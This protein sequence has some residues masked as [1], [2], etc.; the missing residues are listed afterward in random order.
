MTDLDP[1]RIKLKREARIFGVLAR[2][3]VAVTLMGVGAQIVSAAAPLW[4]GGR[5]A[6]T[7]FK[8]AEQAILSVPALFY[9]NSLTRAR[10]VFRRIGGGNLFSLENN[11]GLAAMGRSLLIGALWAMA[12]KGLVPYNPQDELSGIGSAAADICFG[13]AGPGADHDRAGDERSYRSQG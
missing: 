8:V 13:C 3:A 2:F 6:E 5:V 9:I 10:R 11:Q 1:K 4:K 12:A 7:L